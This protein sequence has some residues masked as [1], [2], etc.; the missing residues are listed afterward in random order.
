M[1]GAKYV[2]S[3]GGMSRG[4]GKFVGMSAKSSVGFAAASQ[5]SFGSGQ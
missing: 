2:R 4:S 3:G 1:S 5:T